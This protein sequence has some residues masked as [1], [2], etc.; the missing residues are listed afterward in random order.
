MTIFLRSR[1]T[2]ADLRWKAWSLHASRSATDTTQ[3][4]SVSGSPAADRRQ[5]RKKTAART[6][7][8]SAEPDVKRQ[9]QADLRSGLAAARN[10][11]SAEQGKTNQG[12]R[13]RLG[14]HETDG[15]KRDV[16]AVR[17]RDGHV[18]QATGRQQRC[19]RCAQCE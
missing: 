4:E 14:D 10:H 2:R 7:A 9:G 13:R 11:T 16:V 5:A 18:Q 6:A 1:S 19:L 17:A 12:Q 3:D 15:V 8:V